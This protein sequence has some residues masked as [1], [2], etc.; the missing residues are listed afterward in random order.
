[1]FSTTLNRVKAR[2]IRVEIS[3]SDQWRAG[4]VV[5]L[6]NQEVQGSTIARAADRRAVRS[7]ANWTGDIHQ[8]LWGVHYTDVPMDSTREKPGPSTKL[9][10]YL[11]ARSCKPLKGTSGIDIVT[12]HQ[13][14]QPRKVEKE[15]GKG[16]LQN[17]KPVWPQSQG[18]TTWAP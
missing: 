10:E 11:S 17:E 14:H 1:M 5:I 7:V 3:E 9:Q 13:P 18:E 8:V 12:L 4:D 16:R 2:A 15:E 6:R